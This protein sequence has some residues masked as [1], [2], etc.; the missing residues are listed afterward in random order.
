MLYEVITLDTHQATQ[1]R[2]ADVA[3]VKIGEANSVI[4]RQG[5]SRRIDI[6]ADVNGRSLGEVTRE[7]VR[8]VAAVKFPFEYHAQV[9]GE[10]MERRRITSYNV[11]Y[12]KLL[13]QLGRVRDSELF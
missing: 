12:T 1:V 3:T 7:A 11:C 5:V 6:D 2:L 4:R 10:Q 8:K 9:R 13:R